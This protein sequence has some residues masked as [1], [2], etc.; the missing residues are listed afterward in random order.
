[1]LDRLKLGHRPATAGAGGKGDLGLLIDM[2]GNGTISP[3]VFGFASWPLLLVH[4]DLLA[5]GTTEGGGL[6][7]GGPEGFIELLAE[8]VVLPLQLIDPGAQGLVLG[9]QCDDNHLGRAV[10]HGILRSRG[11]WELLHCG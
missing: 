11:R 7:C 10:L 3:L 1:M 5:L 4:G 2:I 6:A 8:D 9:L